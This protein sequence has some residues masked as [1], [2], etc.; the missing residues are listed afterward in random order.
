MLEG[1]ENISNNKIQRG[2]IRYFAAKTVLKKLLWNISNRL[3]KKPAN[4][5]AGFSGDEIIF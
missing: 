4:F 3:L 5:S 1:I 2:V